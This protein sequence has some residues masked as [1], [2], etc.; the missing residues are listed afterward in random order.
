MKFSTL[1]L[2]SALLCVYS[3]VFS[4]K[5]QAKSKFSEVKS[6]DF[7]P[8][9]YSIDSSANAIVL[10][11]IG[12]S[13]FIGNNKGDFSIEFVHQKRIRI[14][15]KNGFEQATIQIPLY[16]GNNLEE[17]LENIEAIT[18]NLEGGQVV[19]TKLEKSAIFKE[20]YD[21]R[22]IIR[23]FTFPNIKEGSIIEYK[24]KTSSPFYFNLQPWT[25]QEEIPVLWSEYR[26]TIPNS[27]FD[28]VFMQQGYVPY[29]IENTTSSLG[30]YNILLSNSTE[31]S[32]MISIHSNNVTS[33][34]AMADVP[35]LKK[36]TYIT[37]MENYAAKIDFQL[38]RVK[39]SE[40]HIEE[41]MGNWNQFVDRLMKRE[42]FG[43][44]LTKNNGWLE[45]DLKKITGGTQNKYEK[46]KKIYEYIRDNFT[47]KTTAGMY[48]SSS[49]KKV[50]QDKSGNVADINLLLTAGL[51]NQGFE[52][53]P[54]ILS[55]K[56]N[57]RAS[58]IYPLIERFNYVICQVK[59]DGREY[60]LDA[61]KKLGFGKLSEELYNGSARL[62]DAV[63]NLIILMPDSLKESKVTTVFIANGANDKMEGAFTTTLGYFESLAVREKLGI[64][65]QDEFFKEIK[66]AYSFDVEIENEKID[67]LKLLENPITIKYDIKFNFN[68][69]DL[70]YFNP[71]LAEVQRE[72]PFA[73]AD[74]YYPVEMSS[75]ID[76]TYVFNMDVPTGYAV[77]ELPKSARVKFNEDEGMFEYIIAK[78]GDHIQMRSRVQL[79][80][81]TF[82]PEEY[83]T[84][85]DFFGYI[86]K[87]QAEQI[88]FK[89]IK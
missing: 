63:P 41:Y 61:S 85:R 42:S 60:L 70:V 7:A 82:E 20:K 66:K 22:H 13:K 1:I 17:R 43:E 18:Y 58:E 8:A 75:C 4:Q 32:E 86:V 49:L 83:Q 25:F 34:W 77:D 76:E 11:D 48:L 88:V 81:A 80:K 3:N 23:K 72:N 2:L 87:K 29:V 35:A 64:T 5:K 14:L 27:I 56:D 59:I 26:T 10:A 37:S 62:I 45:S 9:V 78:S 84:L 33:H 57:G 67:S 52:A 47:C 53:A 31:R 30:S 44:P 38:R 16:I 36:E 15:N 6:E 21:S 71:M 19:A 12:E 69:E 28:F 89:K 54:A 24:Y 40:S 39:Y 50:F 73:S 65:K 46:A 74:R 51:K 79:K 68:D 55:T